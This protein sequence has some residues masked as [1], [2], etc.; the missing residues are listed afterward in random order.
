MIL[1]VHVGAKGTLSSSA[2]VIARDHTG[3]NNL[4]MISL[5]IWIKQRKFLGKA[6]MENIPR[7]KF[8]IFRPLIC[9]LKSTFMPNIKPCGA[10]LLC[11]IKEM[12]SKIN[13]NKC[14]TIR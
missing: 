2:K 1:P 6:M 3:R 10:N 5:K 11:T 14:G 9:H 4:F 12:T 8:S 7:R 13:Y